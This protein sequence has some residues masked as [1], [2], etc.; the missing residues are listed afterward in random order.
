MTVSEIEP[1]R[2]PSLDDVRAELSAELRSE[3][4]AN[5]VYAVSTALE[6]LLGGGATL[7][8]A[9]RQMDL[10]AETLASVARDGTDGAGTPLENLPGD[11]GAFLEEVF[12][13]ETGVESVLTEDGGEGYFVVRVDAVSEPRLKPIEDVRAEA[14]QAW[15]A[16]QRAEQAQKRAEAARDKLSGG[17]ALNEVAAELGARAR[18][19]PA[20]RRDGVPAGGK[21]IEPSE[22]TPAPALLQAAFGVG[23]G[24]AVLAQTQTGWQLGRVEAAGTADGPAL[25]AA[26]E[27]IT[28]RLAES[29]AGDMMEAFAGELRARHDV[30]VNRPVIDALLSPRDGG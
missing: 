28:A 17:A 23:E 24:E 4:A 10:R 26:R 13:G 7:E 16:G 14:A 15:R 22:N 11:G 21:Q 9:A 25:E 8:E 2:A 30:T 27:N 6:D 20:L 19:S 3:R 18:F 29:L 5:E 1:G 12:V